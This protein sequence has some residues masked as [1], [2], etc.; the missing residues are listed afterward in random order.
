MFMRFAR[1]LR[2][3][4]IRRR[5][6]RQSGLIAPP[7]VLR[8][9]SRDRRNATVFDASCVRAGADRHGRHAGV[10]AGHRCRDGGVESDADRC[11]AAERRR[12]DTIARL[13]VSVHDQSA[14]AGRTDAVREADHHAACGHASL[15]RRSGRAARA[16]QHAEVSADVERG[17]LSSA[18]GHGHPLRSV[19]RAAA[20]HQFRHH[21]VRRVA[22]D[23]HLELRRDAVIPRAG[24][25]RALPQRP[26]IRFL[27]AAGHVGPLRHGSARWQ[28][29][30][31]CGRL[32]ARLRAVLRRV[33]DGSEARACAA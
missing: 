4:T 11:A 13:A 29:R 30:R 24:S 23:R 21:A 2:R 33:D 26:A 20:R 28:S 7:P 6:G 5:T 12:R 22:R 10:A 25:R 3:C 16:R 14:A 8:E 9:V 31:H 32:V 18:A 19:Q 27:D 15:S 17:R 1:G